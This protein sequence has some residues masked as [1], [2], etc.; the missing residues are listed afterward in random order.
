MKTR[1]QIA[2]VSVWVIL[3]GA[4]CSPVSAQDESINI[5]GTIRFYSPSI[6]QPQPLDYGVGTLYTDGT[7]PSKEG[8]IPPFPPP[9]SSYLVYLD[10][11][12]DPEDGDPPCWWKADLRGVPD[13][14]INGGKKQF[15]IKYRIGV[16]NNTGKPLV[17]SILNPDWPAGV[18]SMHVVD[19]Q[20]A[21]A[22][23]HT[24][25]G[26][27]EI[28]IE[29]ILTKY[30]DVTV[31]YNLNVSSVQADQRSVLRE[32]LTVLPNP[33]LSSSLTVDGDFHAGDQLELTAVSGEVLLTEQLADSRRSIVLNVE[34]VAS[35]AY[36]LVQKDGQGRAVQQQHVRIVR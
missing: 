27:V 15:K 30:L 20:L 18:D 17:L 35:G 26:P 8:Q 36:I 5:T 7:D 11:E 24:F 28:E 32:S 33:V 22:F 9:G 14:V 21:R 6:T 4:F 2:V 12:C 29:D 19:A 16:E 25:T 31:Y 3:I 34:K 10:R 23:D 1:I 13:S